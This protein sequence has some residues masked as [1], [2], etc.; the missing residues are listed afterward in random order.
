MLNAPLLTI[1]RV[2]EICNGAIGTETKPR[3]LVATSL[4]R[5]NR[6]KLTCFTSACHFYILN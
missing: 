3:S 5:Q 4:I 1:D 2:A 6:P